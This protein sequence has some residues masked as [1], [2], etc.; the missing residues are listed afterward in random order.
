MAYRES[1]NLLGKSPRQGA[2]RGGPRPVCTV[3]PRNGGCSR[4]ESAVASPGRNLTTVAHVRQLGLS[5]KGFLD[6][7][8]TRIR[9]D[10]RGICLRSARRAQWASWFHQ[11]LE[12]AEAM[13][14]LLGIG[15]DPALVKGD[16][17]LFLNWIGQGVAAGVLKL[18]AENEPIAWPKLSLRDVL[19]GSDAAA[20]T[21][22]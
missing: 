1:R 19:A 11:Q 16:R 2:Y 18:P 21:N 14:P 3:L 8:L 22:L 17:D 15:C 9:V 12:K 5:G 13:L 7:L 20:S 6:R 10:Q 4:T